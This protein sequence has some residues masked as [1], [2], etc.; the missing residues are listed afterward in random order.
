MKKMERFHYDDK[1]NSSV[2]HLCELNKLN[3]AYSI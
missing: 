2:R 3:K 1:E